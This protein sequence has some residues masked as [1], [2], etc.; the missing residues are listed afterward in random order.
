MEAVSCRIS[1][2]PDE[3]LA[4]PIPHVLETVDVPHY[5][6]EDRD[7]VDRVSIWTCAVVVGIN[8]EGHVGFVVR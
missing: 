6:E 1:L 8:R 7:E 2:G 4:A 3:R 5:L